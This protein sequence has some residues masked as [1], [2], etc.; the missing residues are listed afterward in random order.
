MAPCFLLLPA[1]PASYMSRSK[2][3]GDIEIGLGPSPIE[4]PPISPPGLS[5]ST[6][7]KHVISTLPKD[8]DRLR[9]ALVA[10][11]WGDETALV[12]HVVHVVL[13]EV[14]LL[15]V[16]VVLPAWLSSSEVGRSVRESWCLK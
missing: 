16:L 13:L 9:V 6:M 8:T 10:R 15:S 1:R 5:E 4:G 14:R 11:G 12:L 2:V 7:G 3:A